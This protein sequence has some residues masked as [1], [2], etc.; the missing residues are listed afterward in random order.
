MEGLTWLRRYDGQVQQGWELTVGSLVPEDPWAQLEQVEPD[1]SEFEIMEGVENSKYRKSSLI[2]S[3]GATT[4]SKMTCHETNCMVGELIYTRVSFL[5]HLINIVTEPPW[6]KWH[7]SR[8]CCIDKFSKALCCKLGKEM[9]QHLAGMVGLSSLPSPS[10]CPALPFSLPPLLYGVPY[11]PGI[12][13][14]PTKCTSATHHPERLSVLS[15]FCHCI[16]TK[17]EFW[18]TFETYPELSS[19]FRSTKSFP[20]I[21]EVIIFCSKTWLAQSDLPMNIWL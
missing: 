8:T 7:Y 19:S 3:I 2:S 9:G 4:L 6:M 15:L 14:W 18:R 10:S 21:F 17:F 11:L 20:V 5:R 12:C 16:I 1:K 13:K